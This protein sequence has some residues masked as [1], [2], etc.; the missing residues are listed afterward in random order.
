[1]PQALRAIRLVEI[2]GA[3]IVAHRLDAGGQI[4]HAINDLR[5]AQTELMQHVLYRRVGF[6]TGGKRRP[7][8]CGR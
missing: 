2:V 1:M 5:L 7:A 8:S 3:E 4:R 6:C